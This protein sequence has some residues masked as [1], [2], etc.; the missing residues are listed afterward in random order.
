[1]AGARRLSGYDWKGLTRELDE[2]G[3]ARLPGLLQP[4][5][6]REL[7][8][9]Y[10][11]ARRFRKRVVMEQHRFGQGEYQYF[12]HPLPPLV[13]A[14]R[15]ELYARLA[16]A[17]NA[18]SARLGSRERF[19]ASLS[20]FL[21]R[22]HERGQRRP[23]PLLLH[24]RAGG[25]NRLHQDLYGAVAFPLQTTCLLSKPGEDF[26]GGEFLLLEQR[27]RMQSRGEAIALAQGEGIVFATRERPVA[28]PRGDSRAQMRHGVS[29]VHSGERTTLGIIFHDAE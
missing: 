1:V 26:T 22:C 13:R 25:Y 5:E 19:P 4:S 29:V 9:L 21:A 14:L 24:Y 6:C 23:T 18:W 15:A 10:G 16:P 2:M 20:G 17:A 8:G 28:G 12:A 27:P 3:Y 7:A 11:D